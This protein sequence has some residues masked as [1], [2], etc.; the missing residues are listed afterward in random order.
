MDFSNFRNTE[1][2]NLYPPKPTNEEKQG[3]IINVS[4]NFVF[5]ILIYLFAFGG[6]IKLLSA[7]LMV[8]FVHES[9]HLLMMKRFGY[10]DKKMFLIPF[11]THFLNN[12]SKKINLSQH[13]FMLMMGP[14]PGIL[15]GIVLLYFGINNENKEIA[16]LAWIFLSFNLINLLPLDALDGAHYSHVTFNKYTFLIQI[17]FTALISI[18]SFIFIYIF[19]NYLLVVIPLYLIYKLRVQFKTRQLRSEL[20][21]R[22]IDCTLGFYELNNK[23]YWLTRKELISLKQIPIEEEEI[24]EFTESLYEKLVMQH[25]KAILLDLPRDNMS[26]KLKLISL[27]I[28]LCML[29]LPIVFIFLFAF[30]EK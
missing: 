18:V 1:D 29:L 2:L 11:M 19:K 23:Q 30:N 7:V 6:N 3:K 21:H 27:L 5:V 28:W 8:L 24:N 16:G 20:E 15:I 17:V 12:Q 14:L 22:G 4:L 9:G 10:K 26:K 25:I 13:I